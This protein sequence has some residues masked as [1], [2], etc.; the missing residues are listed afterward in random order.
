MPD[1][2][3]VECGTE[4]L[5][6]LELR[7]QRGQV[8]LLRHVQLKE[9]TAPGN[10]DHDVAQGAAAV[11]KLRSE[12]GVSTGKIVLLLSRDA[13]V[14]R[15]L[16][17][18]DV[19]DDELPELVRFQA[20]VRSS[21][22]VDSLALDYV[23]LPAGAAAGRRVLVFTHDRTRI[24]EWQKALLAD[25]MELAGCLAS[26][27][28]LAEFAD[29]TRTAA[30]DRT[31][32]LIAQRGRRIE[33]ALVDQR[34]VVFSHSTQLI[35]GEGAMHVQPLQA[36]LMRTMVSLG[37]LHPGVEIGQVVYLP[38]QEIDE[39]VLALLEQRFSGK[40]STLQGLR[41]VA[42]AAGLIGSPS[43]TLVGAGL[44]LGTPHVQRIDLVNPRKPI[45]KP[46]TR[47]QKLIYGGA[48]VGLL[49][50]LLLTVWWQIIGS[51]DA[52]IEDKNQL[53]SIR[54][55]ELDAGRPTL[56]AAK[57]ID[58]WVNASAPPVEAF[59][60]LQRVLP[61]TDRIYLSELKLTPD[62]KGGRPRIG[63]QAHARSGEDKEQFE[64]ALRDRNY[65]VKPQ[66]TTP[67]KRDPDYPFSF[68]LDVGLPA[69]PPKSPQQATAPKP[70]AI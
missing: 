67:N 58:G 62:L 36:E 16:D 35:E 50:I 65:D 12:N 38:E 70:A 55:K 29:R 10:W 25:S 9:R 69:P 5:S 52:T 23:P 19:P 22:P 26:P 43:P 56:Q 31:R 63:G 54:S 60:E 14:A 1:F 27:I 20:A 41:G 6:G 46:D 57:A 44:S 28:A 8:E 13:M 11:H 30:D 32:L 45:P 7:V 15:Q 2:L 68:L 17:L 49:L 39:S 37:Q 4:I 51:L 33:L 66:V 48:G 47:R 18:P 24:I 61:G 53:L 42:A 40:V 64:Q 21:A 34:T 59:D 3:V